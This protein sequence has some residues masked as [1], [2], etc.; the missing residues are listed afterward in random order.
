MTAA[1]SHDNTNGPSLRSH[2]IFTFTIAFDW[3]LETPS[4]IGIIPISRMR[5]LR[6]ELGK[7]LESRSPD[8]TA[9]NSD[10]TNHLHF[11]ILL[12]SEGWSMLAPLSAVGSTEEGL[13]PGTGRVCVCVKCVHGHTCVLE[14]RRGACECHSAGRVCEG[15]GEWKQALWANVGEGVYVGTCDCG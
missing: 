13:S 7:R 5:K 15:Q 14:T 9:Q 6:S 8:S 10:Q 1:N 12:P 11:M 4:G 2:N 3:I